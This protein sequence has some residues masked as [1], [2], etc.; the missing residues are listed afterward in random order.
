MLTHWSYVFLAL[1]NQTDFQIVDRGT[2]SSYEIALRWLSLGLTGDKYTLAQVMAWC[3]QAT[4]HYLSQYLPRSIGHNELSITVG[5]ALINCKS[6]YMASTEPTHSSTITIVLLPT[7]KCISIVC[8]INFQDMLYQLSG[9]LHSFYQLNSLGPD[10]T[11]YNWTRSLHCFRKM[12]CHPFNTMPLWEKKI[13]MT[14][15]SCIHLDIVSNLT[16]LL[17][18]MLSAVWKYR[19]AWSKNCWIYQWIIPVVWISKHW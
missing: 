17:T 1:S 14:P 10:I 4:S 7:F 6:V 12:V 2:S 18:L 19:P 9:Q 13:N 11:S 15:Y 16:I 5:H 3:R 8:F